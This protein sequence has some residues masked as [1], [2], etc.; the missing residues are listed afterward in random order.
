MVGREAELRA[1]CRTASG[2]LSTEADADAV[3]VVAEAGS[4]RAACC[5]E[6]RDWLSTRPSPSDCSWGRADPDASQPYG[7]LRDIARLALGI[8][9]S[10]S[11]ELA[12]RSFV[13]GIPPLL[14]R[15]R[16]RGRA[17]HATCSAN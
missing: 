2:A 1:A 13:A 5:V 12:R 11:T 6:F 15:R 10:D 17:A 14:L 7:L 9:D 4:A 3:T 8:A 16:R